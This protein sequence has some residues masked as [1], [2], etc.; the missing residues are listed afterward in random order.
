M[1]PVGQIE[2]IES[3]VQIIL[4]HFTGPPVPIIERIVRTKGGCAGTRPDF[5]IVDFGADECTEGDDKMTEGDDKMTEGDEKLTAGG[6][7]APGGG[8]EEVA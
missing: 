7:G 6:A 2:S 3:I 5:S 1:V 8:V 4:L